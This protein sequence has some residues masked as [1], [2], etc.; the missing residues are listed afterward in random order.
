MYDWGMEPFEHVS[1]AH[2]GDLEGM[3]IAGLVRLSFELHSDEPEIDTSPY[4]M[5]GRDIKGKEEQ[6]KDCCSYVERRKGSY[7]YTYVA[8]STSAWKRKQVP[9]PDGTFGYRV[10]RPIFE[11]ALKQRRGGTRRPQPVA[12]DVS[13]ERWNRL[14]FPLVGVAHLAGKRTKGPWTRSSP[15]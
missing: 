3:K 6:E 15:R 7:V 4:G 8:P 5:T 1:R 11:G 13:T 2:W 10:R 12:S 9:M 14:A